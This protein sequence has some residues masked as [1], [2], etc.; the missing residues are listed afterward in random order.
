MVPIRDR[1]GQNLLVG[2]RC[3]RGNNITVMADTSESKR[4]LFASPLRAELES[5]IG[6]YEIIRPLGQ[7]GMSEVLLARDTRLGRLVAIKR[8]I[9][10][11]ERR[12]IAEA[13]VTARFN[14]ENIV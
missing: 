14:H 9:W 5:A 7:G 6:C 3:F 13:R 12:F 1:E 2:E 4:A 11:C 10:P 8:L